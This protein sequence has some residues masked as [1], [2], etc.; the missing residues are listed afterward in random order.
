[1]STKDKTPIWLIIGTQA[2]PIKKAKIPM[3]I[4]DFVGVNLLGA[5]LIN[6]Y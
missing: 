6:E 1:M 4:P 2:D 5:K 3:I